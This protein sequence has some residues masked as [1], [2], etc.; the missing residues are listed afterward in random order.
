LKKTIIGILL[1]PICFGA[2][3]GTIECVSLVQNNTIEVE[4]NKTE[5]FDNCLSLGS[6]LQNTPVQFVAFSKDNV[7]NK[8]SLFDLNAGGTS[9]YIAE[10]H[11]D[12]GAANAFN[13]N[14]TNRNL[15]FRVTPTSHLDTNKN[16]SITYL[17]VDGVIQVIIDF[18]DI[19][20]VSSP[21]P[22][23]GGC[24]YTVSAY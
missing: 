20:S 14:T 24:T 2:F 10:Y 23:T 5:G 15:S 3:A 11:S 6:A 9:P 12:V 16:A 19:P 4:L 21:P 7:Q 22:Q 1:S 18:D 8:I 17:N 13:T